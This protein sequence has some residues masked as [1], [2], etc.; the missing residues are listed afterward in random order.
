MT[1]EEKAQK[2]QLARLKR[3][4]SEFAG[5]IHDIVEETLWTDY[6]ELPELSEKLIAAV[7]EVKAFQK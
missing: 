1:E 5:Q 3:I 7:E 4:A 6:K 2:K